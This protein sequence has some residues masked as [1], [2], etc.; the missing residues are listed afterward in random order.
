[1][2][3]FLLEFTE[4]MAILRIQLNELLVWFFSTIIGRIS[5]FMMLIMIFIYL[6]KLIIMLKD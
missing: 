6:F 1:M 4:F 5:L 3:D 2:S